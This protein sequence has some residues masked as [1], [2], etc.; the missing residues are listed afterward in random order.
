MRFISAAVRIGGCWE[1][2]VGS[3]CKMVSAQSKRES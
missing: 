3:G 1:V 2:R